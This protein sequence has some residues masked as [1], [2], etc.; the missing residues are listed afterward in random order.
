MKHRVVMMALTALVAALC[1][2]AGLAQLTGSVKGVC[3]DMD[4]NPITGAIVEYLSQDNGRKYQL[5]TNNKGEYFS[6]G[7]EPGKYTVTLTKD[8]KPL[9][10]ERSPSI[11][12][13][14]SSTPT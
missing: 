7:I 4:G 12:T 11:W 6:L 8:G 10:L 5:K 13:K 2:P 1:A 14:T 9:D 3:R